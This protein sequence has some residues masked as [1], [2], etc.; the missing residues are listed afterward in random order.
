MEAEAK[1]NIGLKL[2]KKLAAKKEIHDKVKCIVGDEVS[3]EF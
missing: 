2:E 1:S 3:M